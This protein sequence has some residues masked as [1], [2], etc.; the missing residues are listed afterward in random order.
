MSNFGSIHLPRELLDHIIS[1]LIGDSH[2]SLF[3]CSLV[4]SS[5]IDPARRRLFRELEY[6]VRPG[7]EPDFRPL[8]QFLETT[9]SIAKHVKILELQGRVGYPKFKLWGR[10][11]S[12]TFA[13]LI[14]VL[15][16]LE[17]VILDDVIL[18]PS[19]SPP[20]DPPELLT[21]AVIPKTLQCLD[22]RDTQVEEADFLSALS[23]LCE[24]FRPIS[25][26]HYLELSGMRSSCD[27]KSIEDV[28]A[29][30]G[31]L[32]LLAHFKVEQ[33][34]I[35]TEAN[36]V[37]LL[38]ELIRRASTPS[39]RN[40]EYSYVGGITPEKEKS[41]IFQC[42]LDD[43]GAELKDLTIDSTE[44]RGV[45]YDIFWDRTKSDDP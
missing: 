16:R 14:A 43:V 19:P 3:A 40:L 33:L 17:E 1:F 36:I 45:C 2:Q 6:C 20:I 8:L 42:F 29:A 4:A 31:A 35:A 22:I 21:P 23:T 5:W 18:L 26:V 44:F 24:F 12:Q 41:V 25:S 15:P 38:L 34:N 10:L 37:L 27:L 32:D 28:R 30:C 7:A 9:Y 13:G 11:D 39:L